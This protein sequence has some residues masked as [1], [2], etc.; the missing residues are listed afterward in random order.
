MTVPMDRWNGAPGQHGAG[1]R[2]RHG[3]HRRPP[4]QCWR[5]VAPMRSNAAA[6]VT[7]QGGRYCIVWVGHKTVLHVPSIFKHI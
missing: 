5:M 2:P 6:I 4:M 1:V 3:A 7:G